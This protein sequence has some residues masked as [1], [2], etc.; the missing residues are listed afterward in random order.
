MSVLAFAVK[1]ARLPGTF[2]AVAFVPGE[3]ALARN[4]ISD[5]LTTVAVTVGVVEGALTM[6][7]A[8]FKAALVTAPIR[9]VHAAWSLRDSTSG[10]TL[11]FVPVLE[12]Y[13]HNLN[14]I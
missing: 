10:F 12:T 8:I 13:I 2:V 11:V 3:G 4:L 1:F 14:Y 5:E 6:L 9:I 7:L